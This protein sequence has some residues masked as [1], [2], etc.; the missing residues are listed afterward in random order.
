M[1][2]SKIALKRR[3]SGQSIVETLLMLPMLLTVLLNAINF[4]YYFVTL[5]NLMASQRNGIEYSIMGGA[6]PSSTELPKTGP[7]CDTA[8]PLAVCFLTYEDMRGAIYSPTTKGALQICSQSKGLNNPGTTTEKAQCDTYG[9]KPGGFTWPAPDTDPE[10]NKGNTAPAF[11]LNRMD[12]T[13]Q[14][15]PLIPGT[16]F[17]LALL[18]VPSCTS[19][20]GNVTC[21]FHQFSEMRAM[22]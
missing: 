19:T 5:V 16:V 12:V 8:S 14:F 2:T 22:N 11:V 15:T 3:Q 13:Y 6:T 1:R 17:N 10:L 20:G 4:G 21:Y 18:A 7:T 9:T